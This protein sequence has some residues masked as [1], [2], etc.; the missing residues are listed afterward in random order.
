MSSNLPPS[1]A[2]ANKKQREIGKISD[3][4]RPDMNTPEIKSRFPL[5]DRFLN[6]VNCCKPIKDPVGTMLD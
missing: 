1:A 2:D 6:M 5:L 3:S 4:N